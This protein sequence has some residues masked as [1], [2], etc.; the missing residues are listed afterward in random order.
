MGLKGQMGLEGAG[1]GG[2]GPEVTGSRVY[3]RVLVAGCASFVDKKRE[4]R[5]KFSSMKGLHDT[6]LTP[7]LLHTCA[8]TRS[9]SSLVE[10]PVTQTRLVNFLWLCSG[11][12]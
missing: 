10:S 11:S 8:Y 5:K 6:F 7:S 9:H 3:T 12:P 1:Q 2:S 4:E